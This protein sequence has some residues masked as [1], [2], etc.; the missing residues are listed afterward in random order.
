M[1]PVSRRLA[2]AAMGLAFGLSRD[3]ELEKT[4][5]DL[6]RA[7]MEREDFRNG[8][9]PNTS[10]IHSD[11]HSNA[12]Y[13]VP[14]EIDSEEYERVY[15]YMMRPHVKYQDTARKALKKSKRMC[16]VLQE[17]LDL[18][19]AALKRIAVC[20][21]SEAVDEADDVLRALGYNED[22]DSEQE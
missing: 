1:D 18:T 8:G 15:K 20:G 22:S 19:V 7:R 12:R 9:G 6:E 17:D 5:L 14:K 10:F 16:E 3:E 13:G 21:N 11:P 2:A 4:R